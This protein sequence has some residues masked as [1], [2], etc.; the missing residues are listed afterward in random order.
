MTALPGQGLPLGLSDS[1]RQ[2]AA[3][4]W[5]PTIPPL[6]HD[7]MAALNALDHLDDENTVLRERLVAAERALEATLPL[8]ERTSSWLPITEGTLDAITRVGPELTAAHEAVSAWQKVR[9]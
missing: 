4:E 3:E 9:C 7:P 5:G 8:I 2:G 6:V 1:W